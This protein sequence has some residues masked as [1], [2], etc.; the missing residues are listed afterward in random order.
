MSICHR[1]R[2]LRLCESSVNPISVFSYVCHR[3]DRCEFPTTVRSI[4]DLSVGQKVVGHVTNASEAKGV[5]ISIGAEVSARI[6]PDDVSEYEISKWS[7]VFPNGLRVTTKVT[8]YDKPSKIIIVMQYI[9]LPCNC[10]CLHV[11]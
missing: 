7:E 2:L 5:F 9:W 6:T 8:R 10:N 11:S 1:T 4:A 3:S